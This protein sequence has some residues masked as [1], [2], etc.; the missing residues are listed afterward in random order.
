MYNN[1]KIQ[2]FDLPKVFSKFKPIDNTHALKAGLDKIIDEQKV[3]RIGNM[4][5]T[6]IK[7]VPPKL[8]LDGS[9]FV[10]L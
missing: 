1:I 3:E 7:P 8:T 2:T 5:N 10:R 6:I 4:M 9:L